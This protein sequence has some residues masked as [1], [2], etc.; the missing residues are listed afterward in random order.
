MHC[1]VNNSL[2]M[3]TNGNEIA[4]NYQTIQFPYGNANIFSE[5]LRLKIFSKVNFF[6]RSESVTNRL[7]IY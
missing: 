4:Q 2:G 5:F 7:L 3:I 6:S 1:Y